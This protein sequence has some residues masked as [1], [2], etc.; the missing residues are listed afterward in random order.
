MS[1]SVNQHW[2]PQF[3]LREFSTPATRQ[4]EEAQVWI[5]SKQ[6]SDG[7]ERLTN[8]RNV[9][10]KRYL[11][12]P[13]DEFDQ[14]SWEVD[15]E[16][17]GVE[18]L[19]AQIWPQVAS[20]F[21][22]LGNETIRKALALFVATIHIRHPDN[23]R[24]L[25]SVHQQ[26][27]ENLDKLPKKADGSPNVDNFICKDEKF[28]IDTSGWESYKK[29]GEHEHHRFFVETI[30]AESGNLA[31]ILLKK[32]WSVVFADN[33]HF[34]TSDKPVGVQHRSREVFGIGT[35]GAV[36]SFPLSPTRILMMDDQH[37][38][39]ANQYYPLKPDNVG[40]FNYGIWHAGA[41]FMVTGRP[42]TEVLSEI[43]G[44]AESK[45]CA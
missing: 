9:C 26:I 4:A 21:I 22:D 39:P 29:W 25:K 2:V 11:Y 35:T 42:V 45:G 30:R 16:L 31:K 38:E 28:E 10:A 20:D 37:Q 23:R 17:Q 41:R 40:A 15:D 19:L 43:M 34:I 1:K 8:V 7:V 18:S 33:E 6:D 24:V 32:R 14:R 3:Y 27:V 5:F 36:V 13:R 12:S 44:W